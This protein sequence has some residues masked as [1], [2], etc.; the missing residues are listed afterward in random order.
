MNKESLRYYF[1]RPQ[2][3]LYSI[4]KGDKGK[5]IANL[6]V[7]SVPS[8]VYILVQ[9]TSVFDGDLHRNSV[10]YPRIF[11]SVPNETPA[12]ISSCR[13]EVGQQSIGKPVHLAARLKFIKN[14][15]L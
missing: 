13:L 12:A 1:Q 4:G 7:G 11:D 15:P 8:A 14:L 9:E 10:R 5:I 2:I 6:G 3:D